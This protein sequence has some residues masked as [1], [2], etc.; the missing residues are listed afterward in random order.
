MTIPL[1]LRAFL[2]LVF[3][4][5]LAFGAVGQVKIE[6]KVIDGVT[7]NGVPHA[8]VLLEGGLEGTSCDAGGYFSILLGKTSTPLYIRV[9]AVGYEEY[10]NLYAEFDDSLTIALKPKSGV[11][12][13]IEVG[14]KQKYNN[15]NPAV[16][17]IREVIRHK[18]Y[19]RLTNQPKLSFKQYDKLQ[20]GIVNP[21][22]KYSHGLGGMGFFFKNIDTLSSPGNKLLTVFMQEQIS[23][24]YT[25]NPPKSYKKIINTSKQTEFDERYVNNH[26]IQTYMDFLFQEIELYDDNVFLINKLFLSPI[27]NNAPMFYKYYLVDTVEMRDG[28]FVELRYE[29]RNK[30]D[31][32]LSGKLLI[33]MDGRYAVRTAELKANK[34]ANLNWV[35]DIAIQL[36]YKPNDEGFLFLQRSDVNISFGIGKKEALFGSK[37]SLNYEYNFKGDFS[38][39]VF[40]GAPIEVLD[41]AKENAT[42]LEHTRPIDLNTVE[43]KVYSNFDSLN[44]N[45]TFK[46]ILA[47]GYLAAQ[48]YH[49]VGAFEFGPLEYLYSKNT[50]QGDR[51]R[52]GGRTTNAFSEKIF[53]E[54]YL[55]YGF[56]NNSLSYY[57]RPAFSL[58]G[59]SVATYPAHYLQLAVQQDVFEPGRRVGFRKGDSFFQSLRSNKPTKFMDTYVYQIKH[60]I[61]FGNHISLA[62]SFLHQARKPVGD[63]NFTSSGDI[64]NKLYALNNNEVEIALRWAPMEKF[65]YRNLTRTTV[66]ENYPVMNLHYRKGIKGFWGAD[67]GYDAVRASISKRFFLRQIGIADATL[68]GG[69]IWGT[70]PYPLLEMPGVY[71]EDDRHSFDYYLMRNMEFVADKYIHFAFEHQ[72]NGFILNKIP[73]L[74][75]LKLREI[76]GVK[77]FYGKLSDHNNPYISNAVINFD[78]DKTGNIMTHVLG[79]KPYYE[80][81]VGLDN[82]LRILRLEYARRLSYEGLPNVGRD[83]YRV[84]LNINF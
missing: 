62:T 56:G 22:E 53:I 77:M 66:K 9:T 78:E 69:K 32:L 14:A 39:S 34:E 21:S 51:L 25:Q 42:L 72:L 50:I 65:F 13:A 55:A 76:W 67:Y 46:T 84:F 40:S 81:K 23:D 47:V 59:K 52:I 1:A 28:K 7:G 36:H 12:D 79:S 75:K 58:N 24:V 5:M 41:Q 63:L 57:V 45:K 68:I 31:L 64:N 20:L 70:L 4:S 61:E 73:L 11:L 3:F 37:T 33:S 6:G 16:E 43:S 48:G 38:E 29:P 15:K 80:A 30:A 8:T 18:K 26:N 71:M 10:S 27:A 74:N 83:T 54:S 19:N 35:N 82:V 44:R 49:N 2:W 17:L 60:L